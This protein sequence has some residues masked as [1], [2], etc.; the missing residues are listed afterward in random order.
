MRDL[1]TSFL[2]TVVGR[3][4][5]EGDLEV[6]ERRRTL[7]SII[8]RV[9]PAA[10]SEKRW[11]AKVCPEGSSRPVA[12]AHEREREFYTRVL[13]L[14]GDD[15]APSLAGTCEEAPAVVVLEDLSDRWTSFPH[16]AAGNMVRCC[17]ALRSLARLHAAGV[18]A[19]KDNELPVGP[20]Q[21]ADA[22]R[23]V[24]VPAFLDRYGHALPPDWRQRLEH[25]PGLL[26]QQAPPLVKT[27]LL[28][29]AHFGNL[30]FPS[31]DREAAP[32]LC[33]WQHWRIG[34]PG[35]DLATL[36]GLHTTRAALRPAPFL[37]RYLRL[38]EW[39]PEGASWSFQELLDD[40]RWNVLRLTVTVPAWQE[41]I[42]LPADVW[43]PLLE[44]GMRAWEGAECDE[45]I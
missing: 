32:L 45:L 2:L 5:G 37:Q 3:A 38:V 29:D 17:S 31:N 4:V 18:T 44:R 6:V 7:T 12:A 42:G 28:G 39:Y 43:R 20:H 33:D 21:G 22:G 25:A 8:L 41:S 23:G 40:Y 24:D 9:R 13:P 34:S 19:L 15:L 1:R 14:L 35:H 36:L 16:P 11:F 27:L 10:A 26:A 30:L